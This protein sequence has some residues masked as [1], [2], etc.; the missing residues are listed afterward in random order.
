MHALSMDPDA[1]VAGLNLPAS[2]AQSVIQEYLGSDAV[3][4][5]VYHPR[6][7]LHLHGNGRNLGLPQNLAA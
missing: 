2:E 5:G 7:A 3:D 6:A 4:Q 1:T